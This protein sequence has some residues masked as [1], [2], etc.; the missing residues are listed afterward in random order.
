MFVHIVLFIYLGLLKYVYACRAR[1]A[2][3]PH[4]LKHSSVAAETGGCCHSCPSQQFELRV[5]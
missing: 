2:P 5:K 3:L 1:T 4:L